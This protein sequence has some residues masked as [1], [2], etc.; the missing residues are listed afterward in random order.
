MHMC[1]RPIIYVPCLLNNDLGSLLINTLGA[2]AQTC[3]VVVDPAYDFWPV[4]TGELLA[5]GTD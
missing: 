2:P 4:Q 3:F 5:I 1:Y